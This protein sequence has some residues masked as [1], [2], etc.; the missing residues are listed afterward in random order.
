MTELNINQSLT[1]VLL[2]VSGKWPFFDFSNVY[3]AVDPAIISGCNG[4]ETKKSYSK[5]EHNKQ[6]LS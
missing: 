1:A 6:M 5:Q 3:E 4:Q 2:I